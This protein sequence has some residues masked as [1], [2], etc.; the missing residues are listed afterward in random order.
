MADRFRALVRCWYAADLESMLRSVLLMLSATW[1]L[2]QGDYYTFAVY[3]FLCITQSYTALAYGDICSFFIQIFWMMFYCHLHSNPSSHV[4]SISEASL[5]RVSEVAL[6]KCKQK[7]VSLDQERFFFASESR[8]VG[9]RDQH[10]FLACSV[11]GHFWICRLPQAVCSGKIV[12]AGLCLR[13]VL[14]LGARLFE[15]LL[16]VGCQWNFMGH[17]TFT[18]DSN[19]K[20]HLRQIWERDDVVNSSSFFFFFFFR[21]TCDCI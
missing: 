11:S 13:A 3:F 2:L 12:E 10:L 7:R 20:R 8:K 21:D 9:N 16:N 17:G 18:P 6:S 1:V 19:Q 4:I 15:L 14:Y 5:G